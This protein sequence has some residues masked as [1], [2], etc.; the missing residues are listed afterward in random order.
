M[1]RI[2]TNK[3]GRRKPAPSWETRQQILDSA[4]RLFTR[5]GI[6]A[7][8]MRTIAQA[9]GIQ[10][11]SLYNHFESKDRI[12][13]EIFELGIAR[14]T[15]ALN[16]A[17]QQA[18][19]DAD[20]RTLLRAAIRAH[21]SAFFVY[22]DYTATHIRN[23]KQAPAQV[24]ATTIKARDKYERLWAALLRKGVTEGR[25]TRDV[26]LKL[27]RLLL[28]GSLNWTLEWFRPTGRYSLARLSAVIERMFID[29]FGAKPPART[30]SPAATRARSR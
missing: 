6:A 9:C 13:S 24:R 14:V 22:G 25:L 16:K 12:A 7:T 10:A 19:R 23:F 15:E 30:G 27:A 26:D 4:A 17:M 21:L 11:A 3:A 29:G 20:F 1:T 8:S 28:L 2:R 18:G 5:D